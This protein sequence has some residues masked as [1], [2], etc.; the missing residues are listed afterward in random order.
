[1]QTIIHCIK[2]D[3]HG[4]VEENGYLSSGIES[5]YTFKEFIED[6]YVFT[7]NKDLKHAISIIKSNKSYNYKITLID[8]E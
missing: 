7:N 1:M 8:L 2:T 6:G 3:N 4:F 5:I